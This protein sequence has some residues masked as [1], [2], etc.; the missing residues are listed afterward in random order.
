MSH[1]TLPVPLAP[2]SPFRS[3]AEETHDSLALLERVDHLE[4]LGVF[5]AG[6]VLHL[7]LQ[8]LADDL[9]PARLVQFVSDLLLEHE[10]RAFLQRENARPTLNFVHL[11]I[12]SSA[13]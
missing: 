1:F 2:P 7:L 10:A 4:D 11:E 6:Q 13:D 12:G 9:L 8:D 5:E 3:T